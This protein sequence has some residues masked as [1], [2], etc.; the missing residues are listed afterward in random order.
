[1]GVILGWKCGL[2]FAIQV[3][4]RSLVPQALVLLQVVKRGVA[5]H[6]MYP[7]MSSQWIWSGKVKRPWE[8]RERRRSRWNQ[9]ERKTG[10]WGLEKGGGEGNE[11]EE[12][13]SVDKR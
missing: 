2:V 8:G 11:E 13:K 4:R 5:G 10:E 7:V 3:E 1:M 6:M 9:K 12:R